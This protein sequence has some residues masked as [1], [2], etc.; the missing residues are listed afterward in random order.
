MMT[1]ASSVAPLALS[2]VHTVAKSHCSV[3]SFIGSELQHNSQETVSQVLAEAAGGGIRTSSHISSSTNLTHRWRSVTCTIVA[4]VVAAAASSSS[5]SF[6][7]VAQCANWSE[8]VF[9]FAFSLFLTVTLSPSKT[10]FFPS[11]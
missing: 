5:S 4:V 7:V 11:L 9:M 10:S 3:A 1:S 8:V 2:A 6:I